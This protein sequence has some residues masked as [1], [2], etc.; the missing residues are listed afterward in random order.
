MSP[1]S[2]STGL[3][4][5]LGHSDGAAGFG[6]PVPEYGLVETAGEDICM[7]GA[8][9]AAEHGHTTAS[10]ASWFWMGKGL[11]WIAANPV[12]ELRLLAVKLGAAFGYSPF[13]SYF[14]LQRDTGSDGSLKH[15]LVPRYLLMLY[16]VTG[17]VSFLVF[18]RK[19]RVL[20]L[21]LLVALATSLVFFHSERY[22]IPALPVSLAMASAGLQTLFE[23]LR[24]R[25]KES[26]IAAALSLLL[27]S[28][29]ALWPVPDVPEGQYLYNRAVKA[30]NMQNYVM[31]LSLFERAA[32]ASPP[33]STVREQAELQVQRIEE[34][35]EIGD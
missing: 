4:F 1:F 10:G 13:D 5:V 6:P 8:R 27:M 24:S 20:A 30:Y 17:T 21:P 34:A 31:A 22:W 7:V 26:I 16:I 28:A 15:L 32:E 23:K 33:G 2:T 25:R 11:G 35:L 19:G 12:G 14:D 9:V 29:G 3:N 18:R